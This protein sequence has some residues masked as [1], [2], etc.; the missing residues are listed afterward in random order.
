MKRKK[1][2]KRNRIKRERLDKEATMEQ[3]VEDLEALALAHAVQQSVESQNQTLRDRKQRRGSDVEDAMM[4]AAM[5]ESAQSNR[6]GGGGGG[7]TFDSLLQSASNEV[8]EQPRVPVNQRNQKRM[9]PPDQNKRNAVG[10]GRSSGAGGLL[11]KYEKQLGLLRE[12]G[13]ANAIEASTAL[14]ASGGDVQRAV[15]LLTGTFVDALLLL[16]WLVVVGSGGFCCCGLA[17][18]SPY[19][20]F[21]SMH[22]TCLQ[23]E[24]Q[25]KRWV[26]PSMLHAA[27]REEHRSWTANAI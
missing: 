13:F 26:R 5:L 18:N 19:C 15:E 11:N 4:N 8:R 6:G 1:E 25:R 7:G 12:M 27:V 22:S 17:G 3:Q 23:V 21:V 16:L 24:V 2:E 9:T 20:F 14:E 10:K